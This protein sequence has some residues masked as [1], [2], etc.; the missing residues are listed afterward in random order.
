V[1]KSLAHTLDQD[2]PLEQVCLQYMNIKVC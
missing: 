2:S 1:Y